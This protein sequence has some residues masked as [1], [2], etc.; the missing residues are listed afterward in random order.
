MKELIKKIKKKH[1]EYLLNQL[2]FTN[3]CKS[4][5]NQR[6][7]SEKEVLH[8]IKE[9]KKL[10]FAKKQEHY[11]L[12][13]LEERYKLV[14]KISSKYSLIIIISYYPKSLK[15]INTIKTSKKVFEKWEKEILQ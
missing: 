8:C 7:I 13:L 6:N 10:Y 11:Y 5:R 12:G 2:V 3:Y 1:K 15:I 4:R 9:S 14:Y